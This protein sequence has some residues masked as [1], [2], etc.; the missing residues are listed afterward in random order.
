MDAAVFT[1]DRTD[2]I[3]SQKLQEAHGDIDSSGDYTAD[4]YLHS[5]LLIFPGVFEEIERGRAML[6]K[7]IA[8][9]YD[10]VLWKPDFRLLLFNRH[11]CDINPVMNNPFN[12]TANTDMEHVV[13]FADVT[14]TNWQD[15][16]HNDGSVKTYYSRAEAT[17]NKLLTNETL[18]SEIRLSRDL[19]GIAIVKGANLSKFR[20]D[21][22]F[23]I[24]LQITHL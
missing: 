3:W 22:W 24:G 6:V 5:G 20:D 7:V 14:G 15:Q 2:I 23:K 21:A 16:S 12:W 4:D 19:Y 8:I 10:T 1:K 9:E 13:S 11:E 17:A 18:S